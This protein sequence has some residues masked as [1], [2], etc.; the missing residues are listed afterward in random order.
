MTLPGYAA[1]LP[2]LIAAS[3]L[4]GRGKGFLDCAMNTCA[5]TVQHRWS[6]PIMSAFH[7]AFSVSGLVG[8]VVMG[9]LFAK[10]LSVQSGLLLLMTSV[11]PVIGLTAVERASDQ[12]PTFVVPRRALL[13]SD[14]LSLALQR[15]AS[16]CASPCFLCSSA[17][18]VLLRSLDGSLRTA[19]PSPSEQIDTTC[20]PILIYQQRIF[21]F[22]LTVSPPVV[23][24]D[25]PSPRS[26]LG[27][28]FRH[29]IQP[30]K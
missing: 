15:I 7:A 16:A 17:P 19:V 27:A 29:W 14:L 6:S 12:S 28:R 18:F 1:S 21:W 8:S 9:L 25:V 5:A 24:I 23:Q 26:R 10:G 11:M 3:F 2:A 4:L 30:S 22:G 13:R 20:V